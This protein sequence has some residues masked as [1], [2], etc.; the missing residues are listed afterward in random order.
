MLCSSVWTQTPFLDKKNG[1]LQ[2]NYFARFHRLC[3]K[4]WSLPIPCIF[5]SPTSR[6][7]TFNGSSW[8]FYAWGLD[9]IGLIIPKSLVKHSYI[10]DGTNYFSMWAEDVTLK[11]CK[12]R[13]YC[14]FHLYWDH[15]S[16]W[17]TVADNE[18]HFYKA[19]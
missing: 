14:K 15:L 10:F 6:T 3:N 9:V 8:P 7:M 11:K 16:I 17:E 12:E 2:A 1:L 18:K 19:T 13:K 4:M 5:H